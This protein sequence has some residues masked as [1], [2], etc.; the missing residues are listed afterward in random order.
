MAVWH[1]KT[2]TL[3]D[4]SADNCHYLYY[5]YYYYYC[6][7]N[8]DDDDN[9]NVEF[10]VKLRSAREHRNLITEIQVRCRQMAAA[11]MANAA[12]IIKIH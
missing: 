11:I 2:L 3:S 6:D 4:N 5:Y 10:Y 8:N 1:G 12:A 7:D 9:S